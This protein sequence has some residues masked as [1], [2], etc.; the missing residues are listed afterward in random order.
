PLPQPADDRV[1][2]RLP[3]LH[4]TLGVIPAEIADDRAVGERGC[5]ARQTRLPRPRLTLRVAGRRAAEEDRGV[6]GNPLGA[7]PAED[8]LQQPRRTRIVE[9]RAVAHLNGVPVR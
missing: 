7:R 5:A 8:A 1:E 6:E 2:P 3:A 4:R 9:E